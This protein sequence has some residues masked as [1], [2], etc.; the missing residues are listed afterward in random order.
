MPGIFSPPVEQRHS[1]PWG[2]IASQC[3]S[4]SVLHPFACTSQLELDESCHNLV[5]TTN[6]RSPLHSNVKQLT[7]PYATD[8][9]VI[10]LVLISAIGLVPCQLVDVLMWENGSSNNLVFHVADV[11]QPL[12]ICISGAIS[13][14]SC[15]PVAV[16]VITAD[17]AFRSLMTMVRSW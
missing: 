5:V 14:L 12:P 1:S 4:T 6:I 10:D 3:Q 11:N 16:R 8:Y 2:R 13:M 7:F 17:L 9:Q 15:G